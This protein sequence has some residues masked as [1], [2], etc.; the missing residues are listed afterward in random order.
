MSV[1]SVVYIILSVIVLLYSIWHRIDLLC[2][3]SV[4]YIIYS[5]Y[6]IPGIGISGFYRPRLSSTLYY[7][8]YTQMIMIIAFVVMM[9]HVMKK[10]DERLLRRE[11]AGSTSAVKRNNEKVLQVSFRIYTL[12]IVLFTLA[13]VMS[14]G[15]SGFMAGKKTVWER[16]NVLYLISLYGAW[17][18]FAYGIHKNDRLVW[19]PS[20]LVELTIFF[21]G[22]RAFTATIIIIF[23]CEKGTMLWKKRKNYMK[24]YFLAA[25]GL[26]FLLMYRA[27]DTYIMAGDFS[28]AI[29]VLKE[30]QTWLTALE[31]NEPRVI[32][33]NYDY[34]LTSGIRFPLGDVLY[35]II[36][37]VPGLASAFGI[38]LQYPEYYSTW[39]VNQVHG[40]AGVGGSIWGESYAMMGFFGIVLFT[41]VWLVFIYRCNKHLDYHSNY[42]YFLVSLGTYL[43]WYIHRLDFNRV[44]QSCKVM[45]LCFMIWAAVYMFIG[46]SVKIGK[47]RMRMGKIPLP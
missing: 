46:G 32:I 47:V 31:L 35:R 27:V 17:P 30:P 37:F 42:S 25:I 5:I 43:G 44:A 13:N 24:I 12:F 26:V 21:A 7:A 6:C 8:V 11:V 34:A 14:A 33:A 16:T 23:L 1:Y 4:C 36:D 39:L 15:I 3:A 20:L 45:L 38:K 19:I 10:R 22:S 41:L 40:S 18:S 28:G 9:R 29:K 2:V